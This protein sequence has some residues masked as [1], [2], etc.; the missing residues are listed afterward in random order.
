MKQSLQQPK[1]ADAGQGRRRG[2]GHLASTEVTEASSAR[3]LRWLLPLAVTDKEFAF[4][5]KTLLQEFADG[6]ND[7]HAKNL[8]GTAWYDLFS[9]TVPDFVPPLLPNLGN[10][11]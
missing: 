6:I 11:A 5:W 3:Q 10:Q 1:R 4:I 7:W 2:S 8:P 9:V